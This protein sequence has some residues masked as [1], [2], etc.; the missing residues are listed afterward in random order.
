MTIL[1]CLA[2]Q[3]GGGQLKHSYGS[4]GTAVMEMGDAARQ[5]KELQQEHRMH[6]ASLFFNA[7]FALFRQKLKIRM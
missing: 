7:D 3:R 1:F 6:E 5:F 2:N 4:K